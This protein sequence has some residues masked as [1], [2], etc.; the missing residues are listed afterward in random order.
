MTYIVRLIHF[1][2]HVASHRLIPRLHYAGTVQYGTVWYGTYDD[3]RYIRNLFP[4]RTIP[5]QTIPVSND[6]WT[7]YSIWTPEYCASVNRV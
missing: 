5:N 1:D 4:Y 3:T 2:M 7:P 6:I